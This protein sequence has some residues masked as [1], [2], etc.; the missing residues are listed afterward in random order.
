MARFATVNFVVSNFTNSLYCDFSS[1][2][3]CGNLITKW[4]E[5]LVRCKEGSSE[6]VKREERD[7]D[8]EDLHED[9]MKKQL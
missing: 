1:K 4:E 3:E 6:S 8:E 7:P 2:I 5:S 9:A